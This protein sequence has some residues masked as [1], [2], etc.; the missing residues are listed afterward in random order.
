MLYL[1]VSP[2][3]KSPKY[4]NFGMAQGEAG[5]TSGHRPPVQMG[6]S[7]NAQMSGLHTILR[8]RNP[9]RLEL[10]GPARRPVSPYPDRAV[11]IA[12]S[13]C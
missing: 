1:V 12:S 2:S 11:R 6:P 13:P 5:T 10:F 8:N 7:S 4:C 9:R 3:E